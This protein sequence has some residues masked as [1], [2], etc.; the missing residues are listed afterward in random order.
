MP[1]PDAFS[2]ATFEPGT[3]CRWKPVEAL[4]LRMNAHTIERPAQGQRRQAWLTALR[5]YRE[6]IRGGGFEQVLD[7]NYRGVRAWVRMETSLAKALA[8]APGE[9]LGVSVDAQW[10]SGNDDLCVAFDVHDKKSDAKVDWTGVVGTVRLRTERVW[11]TTQTEVR[12]PDFDRDKRWLRP[13]LGMDATQDPTPGHVELRDVRLSVDDAARMQ[14]FRAALA[15]LPNA[16]GPLD[17][18]IYDRPDLA[19]AGSAYTCHFTFMYDRSFYDPQTGQYTLEALLADGEREFGGYDILVLWQAYPRIG[20]DQRNQFD[21]YRD[22]PG[23]LE[24]LREIVGQ[25]H[26]RGV[27]VFIDYNPWDRGTRREGKPDEEALVDIVTAI[28][29]DGIFLD[30]MSASSVSLR[31]RLDQAKRGVVLAPEIPPS[32]PQ[33]SMLNAS[34]AQW[35]RDENPPGL[36][37]LK[38]IEPRHMQHQIRRWD[39]NHQAEIESA[40]F[41]GSGMLV[42]ENVFGTYNPWPL[43][44]R[45]L[46]RRASAILGH[47]ADHFTSDRWEPFVPTLADDVYAHAWPG[48]GATVYTLVNRGAPIQGGRL[49]EVAGR[50]NAVYVD[51]WTGMPAGGQPTPSGAVELVGAIDRLGCYL[52]IDEDKIDQP[53]RDLLAHQQELSTGATL[54]LDRRNEAA[55][56]SEPK[57]VQHT[58]IYPKASPPQG[59]VLVPQTSLRMTIE[60]QRRECGCYPDPDA[61]E[62]RLDEFLWGSPHDGTIKHEIGPFEVG[63]F[64]I[65]EAEVSNADFKRFLDESGYRPK[66]PENFLKHWPD[67]KMPDEMADHPVVYV[68][69]D[70]ARAY[71]RWAGKRLPTEAEWHLAAQGKADLAWP[72][73]PQFDPSR[74]NTTGDRTM[75]VRSLPEGRSPY[76]CYHMSGNVWEWTESERDDGHTRFAIIRGGSYFNAE[77]SGWYVSGGPKPCTHH[78]KFLLMWPGLDRCATIGFRCVADTQ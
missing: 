61:P 76:G 71:A 75:P 23:G 13:I 10:L 32:I 53:L 57:P 39:R 59:M 36:L 60:H 70:D 74:C 43:A 18:I 48:D 27:K 42:W 58:Q 72:W 69:L 68:D 78:A 31:Q 38:W 6:L 77:G 30:T 29:A 8:L 47:F 64:F 1:K 50:P 5:Q 67:G 52:V 9:T 56:V 35:L 3:D 26:R 12:V 33:L 21:F 44:D 16:E 55:S 17:R 49:I 7:M 14:A 24:G 28:D 41:N 45:M 65:D 25:A 37:H 11:H 63:P 62:D 73:G 51:L 2:P 40:L 22:M 15:K 19:W 4:G 20:V 46:W 34:W 66:H 54:Q